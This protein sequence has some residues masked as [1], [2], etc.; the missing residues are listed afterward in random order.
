MEFIIILLILS[1]CSL[2]FAALG[3]AAWF[4]T[5]P[6]MG[7]KCTGEDPNANY[8][9]DED[10]D[11]VFT[12]CKSGYEFDGNS[13]VVPKEEEEAD[14][15]AEE[16]AAEEEAAEEEEEVA[17]SANYVYDVSINASSADDS[18][19]AAINEIKL[20]DVPVIPEQIQILSPI[21]GESCLLVG[22]D[23]CDDPDTLG[24][25]D[26]KP[27]SYSSWKKGTSGP[28]EGTTIFSIFSDTKVK[29]ITIHYLKSKFGPGLMIKE[30][31]VVKTFETVNQGSYDSDDIIITYYFI[32][33]PEA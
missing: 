29:K 32:D 33:P 24:L 5:R 25:T 31:G 4:I 10:L 12:N 22:G 23:A 7:A 1:V 14:A 17:R 3:G 18:V 21:N 2:I 15:A 20:D 6:I 8:A 19:A 26:N 11:C 30:N 16:E 9:I 13:C 27:L 28:I